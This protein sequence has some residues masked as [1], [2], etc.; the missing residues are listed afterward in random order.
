VSDNQNG[1]Y[2]VSID[3]DG[4]SGLEGPFASEAVARFTAEYV[5]RSRLCRIEWLDASH[6]D[7]EGEQK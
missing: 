4:N 7:T 6:A 1:V 3:D 5:T 2:I